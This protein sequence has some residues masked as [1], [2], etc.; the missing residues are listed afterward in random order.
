[1]LPLVE[2]ADQRSNPA[3]LKMGLDLRKQRVSEGRSIFATLPKCHFIG[4]HS[5]GVRGK[6]Y[7]STADL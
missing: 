3:G 6:L 4:H 2:S 7:P 1:M 5:S